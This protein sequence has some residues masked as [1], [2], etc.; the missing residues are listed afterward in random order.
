MLPACPSLDIPNKAI[1]TLALQLCVPE[2]HSCISQITCLSASDLPSI[3]VMA[4]VMSH[5]TLDD[6]NSA[7]VASQ[8][9]SFPGLMA[10]R[11][12]LLHV[13]QTEF[14]RRSSCRDYI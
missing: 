7:D 6:V 9:H 1:E 11:Q 13:Y 8:C 14:L 4:P 2:N 5:T 10:I 3:D 12:L